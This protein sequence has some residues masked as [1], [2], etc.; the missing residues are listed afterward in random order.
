MV[1]LETVGQLFLFRCCNYRIIRLK[2]NI[3]TA[4]FEYIAFFLS[5]YLLVSKSFE[6]GSKHISNSKHN[7]MVVVLESHLQVQ[8][9]KFSQMSVRV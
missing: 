1:P 2:Y 8:A 5:Y 3:Y 4:N 6:Y 7:F 9:S